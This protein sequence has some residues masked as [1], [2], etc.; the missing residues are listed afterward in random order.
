MINLSPEQQSVRDGVESWLA[1]GGVG[2]R[3]LIGPAGTGKTHLAARLGADRWTLFC[4]MTGKAAGVL[5]SRGVE[6]NTLHKAIYVPDEVRGEDG[7]WTTK[8]VPKEGAL[9]DVDLVVLDECSMCT[10]QVAHDLLSFGVPVL[11][12]GDPAQLP[13]VGGPGYFDQRA[14]D[15]SLTEIH[16][17]ALDSGILRLATDVREGRGVGA[18][19]LYAP[20]CAVITADEASSAEEQLLSWADV[21]I[22]GTH[23]SRHY[24]NG[25]VRA[26]SGYTSPLPRAGEQLIC[27]QNDHRRGLLNG[28]LWIARS[29]AQERGPDWFELAI[30]SDDGAVLLAECWKHEFDGRSEQLDALP[31]RARVARARFTYGYAVTCHKMQGSAAE[32]ILVW[33]EGYAFRE[34]ADKWRYTAITRASKQLVYVRRD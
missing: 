15:W 30:E 33:D 28:Q 26:R 17:Q 10:A 12:L 11:V 27:L 24:F 25:V 5:R 4:A 18:P 23:R 34:H 2:W 20:D 1:S 8:F 29:D 7:K 19:H 21:I 31:W 6:A 14:P 13:P 22:V 16:R 32:K 9:D 3:L